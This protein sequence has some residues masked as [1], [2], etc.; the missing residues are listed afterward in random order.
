M[1]Y[2]IKLTV[3]YCLQ[4]FCTAANGQPDIQTQCSS[5]GGNESYTPVISTC[6]H[7]TFLILHFY[8][9]IKHYTYIPDINREK[10]T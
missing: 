3:C 5:S 2:I 6:F 8:N 7:C 9:N 1:Q 4:A 10:S